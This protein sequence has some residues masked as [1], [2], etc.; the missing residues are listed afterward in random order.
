MLSVR[1]SRRFPLPPK[2][3]GNDI[4]TTRDYKEILSRNDVDAVIVGTSDHWHQKISID[5]MKAG[6]HVYCEKP[7]IHKISEAKDL[8]KAQDHLSKV[9]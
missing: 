8:I 6:K 4:F 2:E 3:W 1:C 5:A 9:Y 7:V